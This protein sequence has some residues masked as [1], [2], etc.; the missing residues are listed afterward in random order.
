VVRP[1]G[2][3]AIGFEPPTEL[4]KWPGHHF[5]FRLY[6]ESELR[7]LMKDAGFT[8]FSLTEGRGRKPDYFLCLTGHRSA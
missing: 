8:D 2:K 5:G 1:G 7:A 3:L 4:R 6:E